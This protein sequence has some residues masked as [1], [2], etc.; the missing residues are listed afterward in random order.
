MQPALGEEELQAALLAAVEQALGAEEA[1]SVWWRSGLDD[2]GGGPAPQ[3][4]WRDPGVVE[5]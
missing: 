4:A 1:G 5:P 3:Q 2:L